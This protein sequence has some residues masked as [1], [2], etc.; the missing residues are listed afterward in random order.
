MPEDVEA[1]LA[2]L[3]QA[4]TELRR[5]LAQLRP[6]PAPPLQPLKAP[7]P[8]QEAKPL[9]API[10]IEAKPLPPPGPDL[11]TLVG[12]Y[13]MLALGA[14]LALAAAGTFVSWAIKHGL[15]GPGP[16]V[17]LGLLAAA[18]LGAFGVRLRAR[19][20]AYGNAMLALSLAITHVCAWAAGPGLELVPPFLALGLSAAASVALAGYALVH[21]DEALWSVGFGGA[22]L[23]PFVTSTGRGTAPMLTAYAAAVL[24]AGGSA[25]GARAWRTASRLFGAS[26]L[27]FVAAI[28]LLSRAQW[29]AQLALALPFA[30][31]A[32]GV[33]PF[34]GR[35]V[36]PRLRILG[37]LA[38]AAAIHLAVVEEA[39][40][41]I[42]AAL[43]GAAWLVLLELVD[44]EPAGEPDFAPWIDGALIPAALLVAAGIATNFP[45]D[46]ATAAFALAAGALVFF[47]SRREDD[48]RDATALAAFAAA[49][50]AALSAT[51]A[52]PN[53]QAASTAAL[54][55]V[56]TLLERVIPNRTWRWV[57]PFALVL[58]GLAA[59]AA[60]TQRPSYE[61]VPF[62]TRE[63]AV[64]FSIA[65]AF[66]AVAWLSKAGPA[67]ALAWIFAFLW[68][69]QEL[70]FARSPSTSTLLLVSWYAVTGVG[71]V[72]FGRA[73][74]MPRL[75]HIGLGLG[76][77]AALL[78][79]K[80]AWG[81]PS[82]AARI[83]AYLV[84]S[85][86]LLGIAWWYRQPGAEPTSQPDPSAP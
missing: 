7:A 72:G 67:R 80:A 35:E 75:R 21:E 24:I 33:L 2:A 69:H 8:L 46:G 66:A 51:R 20:R 55:V 82:T 60:V 29:S 62:L 43:A 81:L 30:V 1:R 70:A 12:R 34:A 13:G 5:D 47:C 23:A 48:L 84:V 10:V 85:A 6:A 41:V 79:L 71:C 65:L 57:P 68:I 78:A 64:A 86:F 76:V 42:G 52:S 50:A 22:S 25:L 37:L 53:L 18:A 11:E 27:V 74:A 63:S 58:A 15:L 3:E 28:A 54:C 83:G 16:R 31:A 59:L 45:S 77:I 17:I 61:Y 19:E 32:L 26:A 9:P 73:R 40:A 44:D 14:V 49:V 4:V 56:F 39:G 36:R 38:G